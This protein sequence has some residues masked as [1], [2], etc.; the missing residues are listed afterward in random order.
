MFI[1]VHVLHPILF[2]TQCKQSPV[3]DDTKYPETQFVQAV[4]TVHVW[5]YYN[6]LN[7]GSHAHAVAC[8]I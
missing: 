7:P 6:P 2:Y 1:V 4:L 8:N 5:H 3:I